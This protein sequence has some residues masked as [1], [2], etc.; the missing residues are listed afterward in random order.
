M[1][2]KDWNDA[3]ARFFFN[4]N[5]SEKEV[6][7][8]ITK[9]DISKIGKSVGLSGNSSD[10]FEN[11]LQAIRNDLE[12]APRL[13]IINRPL[14]FYQQWNINYNKEK[15]YPPYIGYL[16]LF[17]LPLSSSSEANYNSNNYYGRLNDFLKKYRLIADKEIGTTDFKNIDELWKEIEEWSILVMNSEIGY[18]ELHPF[19]HKKWIHVGKP[20]SQAIFPVSAINRLHDLYDFLGLVPNGILKED[21]IREIIKKH[22]V[23]KLNL[24]KKTIDLILK[25]DNEI[26][27]SIIRLIQRN[28]ERWEGKI[29]EEYFDQYKKAYIISEL[30]LCFEIDEMNEKINH[31]YRLYST[32]EFPE[33]LNLER[34]YPVRYKAKNW[35]DIICLPFSENLEL[36]DKHNNWKARTHNKAIRFFI[37]GKR[38]HLSGWVEVPN[39]TPD[40]KNIAIVKNNLKEEFEVWRSAFDQNDF[41]E[42]KFDNPFSGYSIYEFENSKSKHPEFDEIL[43]SNRNEVEFIEGLK[44]KPN[45]YFAETLPYVQLSKDFKAECNLIS[46]NDNLIKLEKVEDTPY[47]KFSGNT[48]NTS[49]ITFLKTDGKLLKKLFI[50]N[51]EDY[52]DAIKPYKSTNI[53][54][55]EISRAIS[56]IKYSYRPLTNTS[57]SYSKYERVD[58]AKK[59]TNDLLLY[60]LTYKREIKINDFYKA[61]EE[62]YL[63]FIDTGKKIEIQLLRRLSMR[64]YYNLGH[65]E[66]DYRERKI[67]INKPRLILVPSKFGRKASL[68]GGRS[69]A[70][71]SNLFK[72]SERLGLSMKVN[73]QL[74]SLDDYNLPNYIELETG[75]TYDGEKKLNRVARACGIQFDSS[76]LYQFDL[77]NSCKNINEYESNLVPFENFIDKGYKAKTFNVDTLKFTNS[78]IKNIDKDLSLVEYKVN[79]YTYRMIIWIDQ[80]PYEVNRDWGRFLLLKRLSKQVIFFADNKRSAVTFLIPTSVTLPD[81]FDRALTTID[82]YIPESKFL[83]VREFETYFKVYKSIPLQI[84]RELCRKLDQPERSAKIEKEL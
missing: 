41:R 39:Y 82:G 22:G 71:V 79:E 6:F 38:D 74:K 54:D 80:I 65:T 8:F 75:E 2:Y 30:R 55:L 44:L 60:Y 84:A 47:Y 35:S 15:K 5:K 76:L 56:E 51:K 7:L 42:I 34:K 17:I 10:I 25:S 66:I 19:T 50:I 18:F 36:I 53:D 31:Y 67:L 40:I 32:N 62:M 29:E 64:M 13:P 48:K 33:N 45:T 77:I 21:K 37:N 72:E 4:E 61:F 28:Y 49:S 27:L 83:K 57:A 81:L 78:K 23:K 46:E 43:Y 20:L 16:V 12:K 68:I 70:L 24:D 69:K 73:E 26:G 59:Y 63:K 9:N 3:I 11:Y 1:N 14:H 52:T 58:Y